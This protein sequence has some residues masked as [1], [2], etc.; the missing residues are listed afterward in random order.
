MSMRT[1]VFAVRGYPIRE[2]DGILVPLLRIFGPYFTLKR[3]VRWQG[4]IRW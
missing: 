4:L 3:A 1:R 2:E